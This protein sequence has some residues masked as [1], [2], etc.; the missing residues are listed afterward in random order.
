M[1][2]TFAAL[3]SYSSVASLKDIKSPVLFLSGQYDEVVPS[4]TIEFQRAAPGSSREVIPNAAHFMMQDNP[5][6]FSKAVRDWLRHVEG[7]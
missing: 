2:S 4:R 1:R 3:K 5:D 7:E 6:A